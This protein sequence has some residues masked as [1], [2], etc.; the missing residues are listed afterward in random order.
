MIG[1]LLRRLA[2]GAVTMLV[3]VTISFFLQ[4]LAPG[5]PFDAERAVD[6]AVRAAQEREWGLD[7]PLAVQFGRYLRGLCALPPD[8]KRS[9]TRP[10]FEVREILAPRLAV[11]LSLGAAVLLFSLAVGV[12]LG[13]LA[14]LRR[15]G[16]VDY[17]AMFIAVVGISVPN[18]V[19]GP[20][21]KWVFAL[22]LGW[23]PESRWVSPASMV[24][25]T[26]ALSAVYIATIARLVRGATIETLAEPWVRT[27]RGKGLSER[28]VLFRHVLPGALLPLISYLGPAAA[29]LAVGSV[30]VE[31]VFNIP[32]LGN[33]FVESAFNRD[34][35]MVMGTVIT[36]S[37][38][39]ILMN[40]LSDLVLMAVDPRVRDAG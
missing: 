1:L 33:E 15:G 26:L 32:G 5:G 21:L 12:P 30:V 40:I 25:P 20:L 37:A 34:Y 16:K 14:G 3:I 27:A 29:G 13:L 11:S 17:L 9:M 28:R 22:E 38:I 31:R 2:L 23:L 6:P 36:Y 7:Q 10:D 4:R 8:F 19:L 39:L 18:F 35:T 24:L